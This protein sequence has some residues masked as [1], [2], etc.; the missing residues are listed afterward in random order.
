MYLLASHGPICVTTAPRHTMAYRGGCACLALRTLCVG[1]AWCKT[2]T[3]RLRMACVCV[4]CALHGVHGTLHV[5][6]RTSCH[7]DSGGCPCAQA[8]DELPRDIGGR[9][10][11]RHACVQHHHRG[12]VALPSIARCTSERKSPH[13]LIIAFAA[14]CARAAL[15]FAEIYKM[16]TQGKLAGEDLDSS[17]ASEGTCVHTWHTHTHSYMRAHT[18][19]HTR[20]HARTHTVVEDRAGKLRRTAC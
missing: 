17:E 11:E 10:R 2:N 3:L 18:R 8:R 14:Q 4:N 1:V 7:S 16:A 19:T 9:W 13:V 15:A 5:A 20:T 6:C 12:C